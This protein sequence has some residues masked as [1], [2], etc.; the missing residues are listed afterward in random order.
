MNEFAKLIGPQLIQCDIPYCNANFV[1][2]ISRNLTKIEEFIFDTKN[3][4]RKRIV[5][6][7]K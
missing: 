1:K 4:R 7:S 5:Q 2:I 3:K 6:L